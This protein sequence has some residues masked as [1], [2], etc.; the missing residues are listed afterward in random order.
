MPPLY[1]YPSFYTPQPL[2]QQIDPLPQT[3]TP[4][5]QN[6]GF[7]TV[8]SEDEAKNYPV[9]QGTSVTFKNETAPYI[10]TKT[11][12][13]SQLD[14]P[15]FDKFKLV[16]EDAQPL[17]EF[18]QEPKQNENDDI[19]SIEKLKCEIEALTHVREAFE[20]LINQISSEKRTEKQNGE[21]GKNYESKPPA[22]IK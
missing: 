2:Q 16:K 15:V 8:R 4:Q 6:G 18:A 10:Y 3:R 13:F 1:P 7:V 5:I 14:R 12:G 11:M 9:A 21:R 22:N 19:E 20:N 17:M